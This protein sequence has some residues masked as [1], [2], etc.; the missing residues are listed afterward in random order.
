MV[1]AVKPQQQPDIEIALDS[2]PAVIGEKRFLSGDFN[3]EAA[4]ISPLISLP[5]QSNAMFRAPSGET[6]GDAAVLP[7]HFNPSDSIKERLGSG[8]G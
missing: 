4:T 6:Y 2:L 3:K 5:Y 7:V 8:C 1:N